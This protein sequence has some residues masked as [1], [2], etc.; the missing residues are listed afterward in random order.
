MCF[1]RSREIFKDQRQIF[2]SQACYYGAKI[3]L[4]AGFFVN[5][6]T[7]K[8]ERVLKVELPEDNP[9]LKSKMS[10]ERETRSAEIWRRFQ[11]GER[12]VEIA[13]SLKVSKQL[14]NQEIKSLKQQNARK[15]F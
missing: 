2:F 10:E 1:C 8:V 9:T 4:T 11:A 5:P 12:Q 14:V 6:D 13:E 7:E 15:E 3:R